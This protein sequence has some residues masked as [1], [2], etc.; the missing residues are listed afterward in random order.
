MRLP[1]DLEK[2]E[3]GLFVPFARFDLDTGKIGDLARIRDAGYRGIHSPSPR[4]LYYDEAYIPV[5]EKL[6]SLSLVLS[7][8]CGQRWTARPIFLEQ[9][10]SQFKEL[11][12]IGTRFGYPWY[13]ET[14]SAYRPEK[15]RFDIAPHQLACWDRKGALRV[16]PIFHDLNCNYADDAQDWELNPS[17][18]LFGSGA[19]LSDPRAGE[20]FAAN[21]KINEACFGMLG[22]TGPTVYGLL[23]GNAASLLKLLP[24]AYGKPTYPKPAAKTAGRG[25]KAR[26]VK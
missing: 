23:G 20:V 9:I 18:L 12:V 5:Y 13:A 7:A 3:P 22:W 10:C 19:S 8:E 4:K 26:R 1:G 2:R 25:K 17:K 24:V 6:Q 15:L 16:K 11:V 21:L 14:C